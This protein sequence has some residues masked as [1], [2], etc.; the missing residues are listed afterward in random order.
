MA[1][2]QH[3]SETA[4]PST[5]PLKADSIRIGRQRDCELFL[6]SKDVSRYHARIYSWQ[7]QH[8]IEDLDSRNG[9]LVN[10]TSIE[11]PVVLQDGDLIRFSSLE[12]CYLSD[13][14]LS[15]DL[16][17]GF[18]PSVFSLRT[19]SS[20]VASNS[21]PMVVR[22]GDR[23]S[24][25]SLGRHLAPSDD[26]VA[27]VSA[28]GPPDGWPTLQD[29]VTKLENVLDL[30]NRLRTAGLRSEVLTAAVEGLLDAFDAAHSV[31]ILLRHSDGVGFVV[32]AA[33]ARTAE[34]EVMIS[35]PPLVA[36]MESRESL[37]CFERQTNVPEHGLAAM[38]RSVRYLLCA[39][40]TNADG[41][42]HGAIQI[43][44]DDTNAFEPGHVGLLTVMAH[45]VSCSVDSIQAAAFAHRRILL[46]RSTETADSL[47]RTIAP[48][49]PPRVEGFQVRHHVL[50]VPEI[51]A[52]LVDTVRLNDGRLA[53]FILDVPGRGQ[54][55]AEL[56]AGIASVVT[57]TLIESGSPADAIR[58]VEGD[59]K[60]RM[61][62]VPLVTSICIAI[63]DRERSTVT[64][65][66][67]GHC[68][69]YHLLGETL[70]PLVESALTGPPL[71]QP[72]DAYQD[73]EVCLAD[74]DV[75]LLCSDGI[76]KIPHRNG[77]IVPQERI[78]EL[79]TQAAKRDRTNLAT[80]IAGQ[81]D[82]LRDT[83]PL[84]DD[85]ALLT[86]HKTDVR[87]KDTKKRFDLRT[88][89]GLND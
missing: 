13:E 16:S 11:V 23:I 55:A 28:G 58:V 22:Q 74:D 38:D 86:I 17:S 12:F 3:K 71:G 19:E 48:I 81:I 68:P 25:D 46:N 63:L 15:D 56:M 45:V 51:A 52:D 10:G 9:T 49:H 54:Q 5:Y 70:Q 42:A 39:P 2:L 41:S 76:A 43:E 33:G 59:L 24:L 83:V 40:L 87:Q 14:P 47:R 66:V 79:L 85:V 36:A 82:R 35:L 20:R 72:R 88:T 21:V 26:V 4:P 34:A 61:Q 31:T 6:D 84:Q 77:E 62:E 7:G 69:A 89:G 29:P 73:F 60:S 67:A 53:C 18:A 44:S 57:R 78:Q 64:I 80:Q 27:R 8:L 1:V 32:A 65:S 30:Q 50:A 37:L 75:L